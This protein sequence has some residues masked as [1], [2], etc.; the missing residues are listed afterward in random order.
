M[1]RRSAP[2]TMTLVAVTTLAYLLA[3]LVGET[4]WAAVAGGFIPARIAGGVMLEGAAPVWL[5]PLTATLVHA[6]LLHLL[7]NMVMLGYCGALVENVLGQA[8][9][10]ILYL[11]GAYA[12]AG[13]QYVA[14]PLEVAPMV[15][16]SGAASAVLGAYALF[17]GRERAAVGHPVLNRWINIAWLAA[18]WTGIQLLFGYAGASGGMPIAIA[19][20]IGGFIAGLLL[21]RPLLL[22]RYRNA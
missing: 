14:G 16:A 17:Y 22:W 3:S 6:G 13:A 4:N 9:L 1:M 5:T 11:I 7:F 21:G 15:G 18:A 20:H 10:A 2:A 12:A 19:A 8:G